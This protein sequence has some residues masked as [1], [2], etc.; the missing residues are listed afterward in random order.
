MRL[1][2]GKVAITLVSVVLGVMLAVQY[3]TT[4][5][6]NTNVNYQRAEGLA[7]QLSETERQ[8]EDLAKQIEELK[9]AGDGQSTKEIEQLKYGAGLLPLVG[10]GV[11]VTVNDSQTAIKTGENPNLYLIHD[12]DLLRVINEL[13]A[14]GAEAIAINEQRLIGTSE[15]RC[16]GPTVTINGKL[17]SPPYVIR[18]I[19]DP[20]VLISALNMR[21][22]VVDTLKYWGIQVK[23]EE[24]DK[25]DVPAYKGV[26][27]QTFSTIAEKA[28]QEGLS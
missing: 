12:E 7:I 8:R 20:K 28:E 18:A 1:K 15:V 2:Q 4:Q 14:A 9:T 5:D 10:K 17:L 13:R 24:S 6:L 25:V 3:R 21:G 23:V 27:R 22:G 11:I 19:G 26:F 16:A